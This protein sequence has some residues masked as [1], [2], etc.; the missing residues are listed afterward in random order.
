MMLHN[1]P[2]YVDKKLVFPTDIFEVGMLVYW[3][4]NGIKVYGTI[5]EINGGSTKD[6]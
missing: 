5:L 1:I 3:L 6:A 2:E 4:Y